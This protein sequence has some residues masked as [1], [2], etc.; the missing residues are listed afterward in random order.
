MSNPNYF[1]KE[2]SNKILERINSLTP[3]NQ[4][5][6]GTMSV[7][8]MLA[9]CNVTYDML[10]T[11]KYP[12]PNFLVQTLLKLF[13]KPTVV[14]DKPYK[15]Q[16]QT[17][18]AFII[19]DERNFENEKQQLIQNITKTVALG[20][21]YFEGKASHSFGKLTAKEWNNMFYKHLD[22]HLSQF[23]A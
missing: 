7:S 1:S 8:Q 4:A 9:H 5:L 2:V 14:G 19:K 20:E 18:P 13:V 15:K 10:F 6:W 21:A 23:G 3:S 17:A 11:D 22:H 12:K 16:S